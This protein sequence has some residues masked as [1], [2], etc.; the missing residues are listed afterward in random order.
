MKEYYVTSLESLAL[1]STPLLLKA[2]EGL[3]PDIETAF[4]VDSPGHTNSNNTYAVRACYTKIA[5]EYPD[6]FLWGMEKRLL[7]FRR[8]SKNRCFKR[9]KASV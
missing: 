3:L 9:V 5:K 1:P 6:L 8:N 7:N 4:S 2:A